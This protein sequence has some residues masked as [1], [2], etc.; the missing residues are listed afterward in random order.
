MAR[1]DPLYSRAHSGERSP[2]T[3][4]AVTPD[5]LIL[6]HPDGRQQRVALH[7]SRFW[8]HDAA[9]RQRF[10][11]HLVITRRVERVDLITPPENGTIA[12]RAAVVPV[13][14]ATAAVIEK[15]AWETVVSWLS[16]NGLLSG[17]T[18]V[19]LTRLA[20]MATPELAVEIGEVMAE[21][22][23]ELASS[24]HGPL[25]C[26]GEHDWLK[27]LERA[28]RTS[29]SAGLALR[30]ANVAMRRRR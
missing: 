12:P 23:A 26:S 7:G 14:P 11:K 13:V 17:R 21:L 20:C 24:H 9:Y 2:R 16:G 27:P 25:R 15:P 22:A 6:S 10:V 18:I 5:T 28:A 8:T 1:C 4:V 30:A 29:A 3:Q 19:E